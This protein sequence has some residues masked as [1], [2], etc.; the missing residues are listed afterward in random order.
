MIYYIRILL[1]LCLVGAGMLFAESYDPPEGYYASLHGATGTVLRSALHS[2]IRNHRIFSYGDARQI[3]A[4]LDGDRHSNGFIVLTYSGDLV[5]ET[6]DSGR[7]WNR[8]H[9][10]PKSRMDNNKSGADYSDLFN[11]RPCNPRVNSSRGNK[12]FDT[13]GTAVSIAPECRSDFDSWEPRNSEK[14]DI[15]RA[16]MY[17]ALRYNGDDKSTIDL[18]LS[19]T[20]ENRSGAGVLGNLSALLAWHE[21]DPVS[22]DEK[23]R[24]HL[25]Y[26]KYQGHRNPFVDK[27]ELVSVLFGTSVIS[28]KAVPTPTHAVRKTVHATNEEGIRD[29]YIARNILTREAHPSLKIIFNQTQ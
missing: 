6:W 10:W 18:R 1:L 14:G 15:A 25:I 7:T 19:A 17:M 23:L 24:N 28:S 16:M 8:E 29:T 12:F 2:L 5:P 9:L 11:L 22:E 20:P 21:A 27:P 13:G 26:S 3:L 4:R